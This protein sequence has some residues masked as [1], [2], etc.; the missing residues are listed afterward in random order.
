MFQDSTKDSSKPV[1]ITGFGPIGGPKHGSPNLSEKIVRKLYHDPPDGKFA[2]NNEEITIL[3]GPGPQAKPTSILCSYDHD[4]TGIPCSYDCVK[5]DHFDTWLKSTDARIYVHLGIAPAEDHH[6]VYFEKVAY[7]YPVNRKNCDPIDWTGDYMGHYNEKKE[8]IPGSDQYLVSSF[9]IPVLIKKV[10]EVTRNPEGLPAAVSFQE[11]YNA[12]RFLCNFLYYRSLYYANC[13]GNANVIF[14]HVPE[15][16]PQGV[17]MDGMVFII[18]QAIRCMLDMQNEGGIEDEDVSQFVCSARQ[19]FYSNLYPNQKV[20]NP[21]T[22]QTFSNRGRSQD[23][24]I[25]HPIVVTGFGKLDPDDPLVTDESNFSWRVVKKLSGTII[26]DRGRKIPVFKGKPAKEGIEIGI[27]EAVK[28]CYRY[29]E[30]QSFQ[31]WLISTDALVYLHLGI[32]PDE[33]NNCVRLETEAKRNIP[34]Q[35][36]RLG[37]VPQLCVTKPKGL[38]PDLNKEMTLATS[39]HKCLHTLCDKLSDKFKSGLT[40]KTH[41]DKVIKLSFQVSEDAGNSLCDFLY[42][43]S[44]DLASKRMPINPKYPRNVLFVHIPGT[45][46]LS[47]DS[48]FTCSETQNEASESEKAEAFVEVVEFIVKELLALVDSG[49]GMA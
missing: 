16:P 31:D 14:I 19:P 10:I 9:N 20:Q 38:Y 24:E 7:N 43:E 41:S 40:L 29:V 5:S 26:D 2:Y 21:Q 12:G 8:C 23:F 13:K 27:P 22:C 3:T 36:D 48:A 6:T 17:G 33:V 44:L 45:L 49:T 15:D 46:C 25:I 4:P 42:H 11:S 35:S 37:E 18:Q 32:R 39:F 30:D 47:G 34:F 1:V 28:V